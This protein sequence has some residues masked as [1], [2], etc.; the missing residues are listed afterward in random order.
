MMCLLWSFDWK[1]GFLKN[2]T[3]QILHG[4]I[5]T[6]LLFASARIIHDASLFFPLMF[7]NVAAFN[8]NVK[9]ITD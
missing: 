1:R 8:L 4:N 3:D 9:R 7:F 5:K 2:V 6:E